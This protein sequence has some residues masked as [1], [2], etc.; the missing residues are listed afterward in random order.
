MKS[1]QYNSCALESRGP[2]CTCSVFYDRATVEEQQFKAFNLRYRPINK[3]LGYDLH[4]ARLQ[5][6][7]RVVVNF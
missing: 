7:M 5:T 6:G 4:T 1:D 2:L 3:C